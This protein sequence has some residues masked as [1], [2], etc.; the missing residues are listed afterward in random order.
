MS[1]TELVSL[2]YPSALDCGIQPDQFWESSLLEITD[3]MESYGRTERDRV[4]NDIVLKH[5][6]A[7]DIAQYVALAFS[8][9]EGAEAAEL[10]DFFP[11]LF[12]EEKVIAETRRREQQL[13]IYKA[14]MLDFT[15]R[16]N[17]SRN[18]GGK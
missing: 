9:E 8:G 14:Q 15:Y 7:R 16:H 11:E 4:K 3:L 1:L 18:G 2:L 6:L 17:N 5:F 13:A 12:Q 10:W